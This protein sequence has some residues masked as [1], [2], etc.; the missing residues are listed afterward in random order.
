MLAVVLRLQGGD[1][2]VAGAARVSVAVWGGLRLKRWLAGIGIAHSGFELWLLP[3]KLLGWC[4]DHPEAGCGAGFH[5]V[6]F[7]F[8]ALHAVLIAGFA[9]GL[10]A[11]SPSRRGGS[12]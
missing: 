10:T 12:S 9:V 8:L 2:F 4:R 6:V 5:A 1:A 11:W 7:G 3:T